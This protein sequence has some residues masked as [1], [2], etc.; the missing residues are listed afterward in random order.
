MGKLLHLAAAGN[1]VRVGVGRPLPQVVVDILVLVEVGRL[2]LLVVVGTRDLV[3]VDT[4]LMVEVVNTPL[5]LVA[6]ELTAVRACSLLERLTLSDR[7]VPRRWN[8][9]DF[10]VPSQGTKIPT[11]AATNTSIMLIS[12]VR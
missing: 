1:H 2:L 11:A 7:R 10:V 4:V 5:R 6:V 12:V 8:Q 9:A 3:E